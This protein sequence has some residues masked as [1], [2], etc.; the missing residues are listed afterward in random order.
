[1]TFHSSLTVVFIHSLGSDQA[2]HGN[3]Y[4]YGLRSTVADGAT[5]AESLFSRLAST[6]GSCLI[7]DALSVSRLT[8][9]TGCAV[10]GQLTVSVRNDLV[11]GHSLSVACDLNVDGFVVI[12]GSLSVGPVGLVVCPS[13]TLVTS[14]VLMS[15][16]LVNQRAGC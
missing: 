1:M 8:R 2:A 15:A 5:Y 4:I 14:I 3:M 13:I 6:S 9:L 11:L 12:T 16:A 10:F 7:S